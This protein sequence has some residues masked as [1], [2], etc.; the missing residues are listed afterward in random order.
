MDWSRTSRGASEWGG[1]SSCVS[2]TRRIPESISEQDLEQEK[3]TIHTRKH[4]RILPRAYPHIHPPP[5]RP[6]LHPRP[7]PPRPPM[8]RQA[9]LTHASIRAKSAPFCSAGRTSG[10]HVRNEHDWKHWSESM[11]RSRKHGRA[12]TDIQDAGIQPQTQT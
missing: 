8:V 11:E 5:P 2:K 9:A 6:H 10:E 1:R 7:Q 4:A 3:H 12:C